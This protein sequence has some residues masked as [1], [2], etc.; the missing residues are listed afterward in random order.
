[1]LYET[2]ALQQAY[3]AQTPQIALSVAGVCMTKIFENNF[4]DFS[5]EARVRE[6]QDFVEPLVAFSISNISYSL[7]IK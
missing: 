2:H 6:K 4:A 3:A 5:D 7:P 1:M